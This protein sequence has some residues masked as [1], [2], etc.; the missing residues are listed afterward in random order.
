MKLCVYPTDSTT[1]FLQPVFDKLCKIRDI[2]P[3]SGDS[4]DDDDFLENL[5]ELSKRAN[6]I[7]FLGHGSTNCLYGTNLNPMIEEKLGNLQLLENKTLLLFACRSKDFIKNYNFHNALGF[8]FIPTTLDDARIGKLHKLDISILESLD[9]DAFRECIVR[10]WIRTLED[11]ELSNLSEFQK[12]FSFYTN[13][14]ITD[15]L[16]NKK[17]LPHY[18]TIADMLYYLKSDMTLL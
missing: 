2:E 6:S 18:R 17:E 3:F 14:E 15:I 12:S 5:E 8:G 4:V 10:I 9:L 11:N 13:I 7:I 1:E 16:I